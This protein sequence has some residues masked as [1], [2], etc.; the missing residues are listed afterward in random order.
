MRLP[1]G[2]QGLA[3]LRLASVILSEAKNPFLQ[4]QTFRFAQGDKEEFRK[5]LGEIA[6]VDKA[7]SPNYYAKGNK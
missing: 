2:N 4:Q 5:S 3:K 7:S 6:A 1:W